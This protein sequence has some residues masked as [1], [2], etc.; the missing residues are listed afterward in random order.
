MVR[1]QR[2]SKLHHYVSQF[3]LQ[4]FTVPPPSPHAGKLWRFERGAPSPIPIPPRRAAAQIDYNTVT[5]ESGEKTDAFEKILGPIETAVTRV[6]R[7][8]IEM[9]KRVLDPTERMKLSLY[10]AVAMLRVPAARNFWEKLHADAEEQRM[11]VAARTPGVFERAMAQ[12][13]TESG[14]APDVTA[15]QLRNFFLERRYVLK[16]NPV[17]SLQVLLDQAPRLTPIF[18]HMRWTI[19]NTKDE[20]FLMSDNPVVYVDPTS[21]RSP[22]GV[23]LL[24]E[25]VELTFPLSSRKCLLATH[26]PEFREIAITAGL[27]RSAEAR[28]AVS[29]YKPKISYKDVADDIVRE[30]N[31]RTIFAATRWVFSSTN[32]DSV[33]QFVVRHFSANPVA[34]KR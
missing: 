11:L 33:S 25:R 20:P 23:A 29:T 8:A 32:S 5:L 17:V 16:V 21:Q 12:M 3:A 27:S 7:V 28:Q 18:A 14:T 1:D 9:E 10:I 31:R 15:E 22:W 2:R 26:D 19:L 30:I 13:E 24:D 34:E 6:M 4:A